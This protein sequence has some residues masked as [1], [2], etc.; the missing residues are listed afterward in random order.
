[1][2]PTSLPDHA[3]LF[4]PSL[5]PDTISLFSFDSSLRHQGSKF[6]ERVIFLHSLFP[7]MDLSK[8]FLN[9]LL[10][11][12]Y[13]T[14]QNIILEI[15]LATFLKLLY[16]SDLPCTSSCFCLFPSPQFLCLLETLS[17][18]FVTLCR[19]CTGNWAHAKVRMKVLREEPSAGTTRTT[20]ELAHTRVHCRDPG[21][22]AALEDMQALHE[23]KSNR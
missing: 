18:R 20:E 5:S 19:Y 14:T 6:L 22:S 7:T 23:G 1:M 4:L 9:C 17:S 12:F 13:G 10:E 16:F 15:F 11:L 2:F 8:A 3:F 21:R